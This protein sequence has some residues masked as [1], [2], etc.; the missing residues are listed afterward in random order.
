MYGIYVKESTSTGNVIEDNFVNSAKYGMVFATAQSNTARNN[1]FDSVSSYEYYLTLGAK[2]TIDSHP[3]SS[4]QIIGETDTHHVTI[5]NSGTI[6]IG[7]DVIETDT[8][9]YTVSLTNATITVDSVSAATST[10]LSSMQ[11]KTITAAEENTTASTNQED[12]TTAAIDSTAPANDINNSDNN[13]NNNNTTANT[14]SP[15]IAN[16]G[17]G[18]AIVDEASNDSL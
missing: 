17:D 13:D 11:S 1:T 10:S 18:G 6:K 14:S 9:P 12:R 15:P 3:F 5:Q 2:I 4:T 8:T 16:A 7:Q